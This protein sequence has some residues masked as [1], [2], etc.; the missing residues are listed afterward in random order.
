MESMAD[1]LIQ[2]QYLLEA[3]QIVKVNFHFSFYENLYIYYS[4]LSISKNL[5]K[6]TF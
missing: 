6:I 4:L 1:L 5:L 2:T 3:K